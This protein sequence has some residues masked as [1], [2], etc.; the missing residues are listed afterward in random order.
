M[1]GNI[2]FCSPMFRLAFFQLTMHSPSQPCT[3]L[4]AHVGQCTLLDRHVL[5]L[6]SMFG[7][8]LFQ[9][10][11]YSL[12]RPCSDIQSLNCNFP[13]RYLLFHS[14]MFSH[15]LSKSI[16]NYPNQTFTLSFVY[17]WPH[18]FLVGHV[19]FHS[20]IFGLP[21]SMPAMHSPSQSFTLSFAHVRP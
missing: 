4:F 2:L 11:L 19:L 5:F 16:M 17:I 12:V 7:Q 8:S 18:T 20:P 9:S 3:F 14:S 15:A 6:L 10:S 21:L 1:F 13:I